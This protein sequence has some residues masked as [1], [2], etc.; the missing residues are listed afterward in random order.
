MQ[1]R[2]SIQ[3]RHL[4]PHL[5]TMP[6][7]QCAV[8]DHVEVLRWYLHLPIAAAPSQGQQTEGTPMALRMT[9]NHNAGPTVPHTSP[10]T[11]TSPIVA[12]FSRLKGSPAPS[13][14]PAPPL[15]PQHRDSKQKARGSHGASH[16]PA[17][18]HLPHHGSLHRS[19]GRQ[20]AL[21]L[22]RDTQ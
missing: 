21:E 18:L 13:P 16:Q 1:A 11:F 8:L 7:P 10:L 17:H 3:S 4:N 6:Y 5:S 2:G 22:S 19:D 12:L 15:L 14:P 9:P 20:E